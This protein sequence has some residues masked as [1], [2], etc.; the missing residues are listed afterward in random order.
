MIQRLIRAP[1]RKQ[2]RFLLTVSLFATSP[3]LS[4][5]SLVFQIHQIRLVDL[6]GRTKVVGVKSLSYEILNT[7]RLRPSQGCRR[8]ILLPQTSLLI[9]WP[10]FQT[11]SHPN[12]NLVLR[13]VVLGRRHI[14]SVVFPFLRLTDRPGPFIGDASVHFPRFCGWEYTTTA[15]TPGAYSRLPIWLSLALSRC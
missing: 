5:T 3:L 7:C 4:F 11:S 9:Q 15:D 8:W 1:E 2:K 13:K 10:R 14:L 12:E 6:R